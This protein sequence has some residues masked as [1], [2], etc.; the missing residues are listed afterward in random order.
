MIPINALNQLPPE[1]LRV[2]LSN[3]KS[4]PNPLSFD[5]LQINSRDTDLA[6]KIERL[7]LLKQSMLK[8]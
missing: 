2:H 4:Q 8:H 3:L 7:K 5:L 6:L 1:T